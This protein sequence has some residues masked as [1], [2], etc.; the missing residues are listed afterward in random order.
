[1]LPCRIPDKRRGRI[2]FA[3]SADRLEEA[4]KNGYL[5]TR[6]P[7]SVV[8]Y[9]TGDL[10]KDDYIHFIN[11]DG[12]KT[13]RKIV[14]LKT[15]L[16]ARMRHRHYG[17]TGKPILR[18]DALHSEGTCSFSDDRK[19]LWDNKDATARARRNQCRNWWNDDWRDRLL[20]TMSHL[21]G[22]EGTI[23]F[24]VGQRRVHA[25]EFPVAVREPGILRAP[26]ELKKPRHDDYSF[27]D[28]DTRGG[29]RTTE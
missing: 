20:A 9:F 27:E 12:E 26:E 21:A 2:P 6:W 23:A 18:P 4:L 19:K 17:I 7:T 22:A 29:S 3:S 10:V 24:P 28:E 16:G 8:L 25:F 14:G 15:L 5:R 13:W 11:I 1:M